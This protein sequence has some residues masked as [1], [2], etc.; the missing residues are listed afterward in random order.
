M[1]IGFGV[2][3]ASGPLDGEHLHEEGLARLRVALQHDVGGAPLV[4][5]AVLVGGEVSRNST[6]VMPLAISRLM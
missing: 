6:S 5:G 3:H 2:A 4:L 1:G